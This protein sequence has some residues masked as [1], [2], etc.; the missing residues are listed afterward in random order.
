MEYCREPHAA[1]QVTGWRIK[2]RTSHMWSNNSG[3]SPAMFRHIGGYAI[4]RCM[5]KRYIWSIIVAFVRLFGRMMYAIVTNSRQTAGVPYTQWVRMNSSSLQKLTMAAC[6]LVHCSVV[7]T[8]VTGSW[9]E[10]RISELWPH[11]YPN[12]D[13][14]CLMN[15]TKNAKQQHYLMGFPSFIPAMGFVCL[16]TLS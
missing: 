14:S 2:C 10:S 7:V 15:I 12:M 5:S 1:W 8:F 6:G 3:L 13:T 4:L 9:H 16:Y 11:W